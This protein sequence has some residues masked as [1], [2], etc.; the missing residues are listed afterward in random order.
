M[1]MMILLMTGLLSL[2]SLADT[3]ETRSLWFD[4]SQT[5]DS[6]NMSTEKTRTEYRN[7]QV[8]DTCYRTE[9][10]MR[11]HQQ[12]RRCRTVCDNQGR[13]CRRSCFPGRR[14]CRNIPMQVPYRCM[15]TIRQSYEVLDY[16]V[17]TIFE[18]NYGQSSISTTG[19][20]FVAKVTGAS[21]SL[22]LNDSGDYLVLVK[23][24]RKEATREGET[25]NQTLSYELGFVSSAKIKGALEGGVRDVLYKDGALFFTL[26]KGFNTEDFIQELKI[27]KARRFASDELLFDKAITQDQMEINTM[28]N[29]KRISID[30]SSLGVELPG[31]MRVIMTTRYDLKGAKALNSDSVK[32]QASANWVFSK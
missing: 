25:L 8:R 14:V 19:E 1:K 3:T 29:D 26:G 6:A 27:Y 7:V 24:E 18:L 10:R 22:G 9:Y 32:T 30:L 4:G 16:Y 12:P 15:R 31:R 11:C 5:T 21:A 23:N 13:N 17:N 28:G 2:A 20:E